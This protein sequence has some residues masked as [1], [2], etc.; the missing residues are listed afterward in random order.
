M[1][2]LLAKWKKELEKQH[3]CNQCGDLEAQEMLKELEAKIKEKEEAIEA[4]V[5]KADQDAYYCL[6]QEAYEKYKDD[7]PEIRGLEKAKQILL[8]TKE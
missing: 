8:G 6:D 7:L 1:R 2:E 3:T 5:K 4:A